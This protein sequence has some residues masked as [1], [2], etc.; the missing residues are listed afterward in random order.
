MDQA[1]EHHTNPWVNLI[2][3]FITPVIL[4]PVDH[5]GGRSVVHILS[6]ARTEIMK[7]DNVICFIKLYFRF[8]ISDG[9]YKPKLFQRLKYCL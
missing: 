4:F 3:T 2:L 9:D 7:W 8:V 6:V 1:G 5:G